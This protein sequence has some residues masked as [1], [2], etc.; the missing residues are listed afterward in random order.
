MTKTILLSSDPG[1]KCGLAIRLPKI[2]TVTIERYN[3]GKGFNVWGT[4]KPSA[5][6]SISCDLTELNGELLG[7]KTAFPDYRVIAIVEKLKSKWNKTREHRSNANAVIQAIRSIWLRK[8][9]IYV[10]GP[11][12]WQAA[13]LKGAPGKDTKE[14]S[15]FRANLDSDYEITDDNE[16]D[17]YNLLEYLET[18]I[19]PAEEAKRKVK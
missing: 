6:L 4:L 7:I 15:L 8:N 14:Q 12:V 1:R 17:A 19:L 18:V 9:K 10:V 3:N 2:S 5:I 16:S 11:K 13:M